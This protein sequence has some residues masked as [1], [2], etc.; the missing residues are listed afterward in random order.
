MWGAG[1]AHSNGPNDQRIRPVRPVA[2]GERRIYRPSFPRPN[3]SSLWWK[4]A[5]S[6]AQVGNPTAKGRQMPAPMNNDELLDLVRKSGVQEEK[7]LD[8]YVDK[9]RAG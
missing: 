8:S 1:P 3:Y 4:I 2:G 6:A 9:L 7:K 5:S